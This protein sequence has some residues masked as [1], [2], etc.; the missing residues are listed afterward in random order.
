M[1]EIQKIYAQFL[2]IFP[3][4]LH[5]FISI[6]LGLFLIYSVVQVLKKDFIY[7]I[8]LVILLP[9]S[10]PIL[11]DVGLAIVQFIKFLFHIG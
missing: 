5:P 9:A 4:A 2:G 11:K 1:Q 3:Q 8:I 10:I 6:L 7:L